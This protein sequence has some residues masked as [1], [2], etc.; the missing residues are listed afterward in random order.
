MPKTYLYGQYAGHNTSPEVEANCCIWNATGQNLPSNSTHLCQPCDPFVILKIKDAW[1][2]RW[3]Q[4][5]L[6]LIIDN[7]WMDDGLEDSFEALRIPE[8]SYFL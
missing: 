5:K 7:K 4:K 2:K 6:Q 8:K 3:E 1:T